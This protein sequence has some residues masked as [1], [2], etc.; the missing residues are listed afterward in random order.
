MATPSETPELPA[1][2]YYAID[3]PEGRMVIH[4]SDET[5]HHRDNFKKLVAEGFYNGTTF[6]RVIAGFMIQ[7]GD[8]NSKDDD[9]TNDGQGGPGYT[10]PAEFSPNLYHK[11]GALA[12]ARTGDNV[13]PERRSSGSQFYIVHGTNPIDDAML[14]QIEHQLR[15]SIPDSSF[16]FSAKARA[17]YLKDGGAPFLDQQYTVFG[18]VVE[19]LDVLDKIGKTET[20]RSSGKGG[21]P[22]LLDQPIKRIEMTVKP[23]ADYHPE[24]GS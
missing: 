11:R 8:P 4:L 5:P 24:P 17:N 10:I 9:P 6:H 20:A 2:N 23:L 21:N 16:H 12:T 19:G 3:T 22:A 13:N 1:T 18:E 7:G 14:D 15:S